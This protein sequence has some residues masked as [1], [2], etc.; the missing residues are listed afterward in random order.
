MPQATWSKLFDV[1]FKASNGHT[2]AGGMMDAWYLAGE[3]RVMEAAL[4]L[5]EHIA[6]AMAPEF[7][8]LGN[9]ER[10]A[11]WSLKALTALFRGTYDPVYMKAAEHI[12]SIALKEQD[13]EVTGA[14]PHVLPSG[15]DGWKPG[16][17]GNNL[18]LIGI[19]L[20]GLQ[21]Y[22]AETGDPEVLR[23]IEAGVEWV[24]KSWNPQRGGWP[25]SAE[26]DG[27]PLYEA[28]TGLN[29]LV[30]PAIA[31]VGSIRGDD[32]LMEVATQPLWRM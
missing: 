29:M 27:T 9:H 14:W 28:A 2:W 17:I 32:R 11:G 13:L 3:A 7:R 5:G 20:S 31:Y 22:H 1:S 23:S 15:H 30:V 8:A 6:W 16:A 21:A 25:Y 4:A 12:A 19:L 26:T 18:Y 24:L 10:T